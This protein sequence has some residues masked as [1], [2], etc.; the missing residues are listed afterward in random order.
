MDGEDEA[1][2]QQGLI[3]VD[4]DGHVACLDCRNPRA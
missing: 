3:A 1:D 2:R 4:N